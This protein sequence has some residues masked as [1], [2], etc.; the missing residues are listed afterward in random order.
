MDYASSLG[1]L[2][3]V[4]PAGG[5]TV[6]TA[7]AI[8]TDVM[9]DLI[10]QRYNFKFNRMKLPPFYTIS[11]Q[12]D[13][14]QL[15]SSFNSPIGWLEQAYWVDI[16]NT[17][18]PKPTWMI[19][20]VRDLEVSSISG[21][22][23]AK[24]AWHYNQELNQGVWP[25]PS[26]V[27]TNP[28]GVLNTTPTNPITN[29]LDVRGNILILTQWGTTG[30]FAPSAMANAPE[31]TVV[32]DGT[33]IWT[34]A[35]PM[36]QGFRLLPLPP[37]QGVCYQVNVIA[38]QKSPPPFTNPNQFIDPIPDDY[39]GY[40]RDGFVAYSYKMCAN[41]EMRK[42]FPAMRNMWLGSIDMAMKQSDREMDNSGFIPDRAS[43]SPQGGIE[44][45]PANPFL[46]S[47]WPG[48]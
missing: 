17:A 42:L 13:Y 9:S 46:Y 44:I 2:Q 38:Q 43:V 4:I 21:N 41:P 48:R 32:A 30:L 15:G 19:E 18:L 7:L 27:Y 10:S 23:P 1:E 5:Y 25:G 39:A 29:I 28:L 14:A 47:V 31:G 22:P 35:D 16:N 8:A 24:V 33:C 12:Q 11:W 3:A 40:F 36:A 6:R 26:V 37:Q 20:V 34:V 45:G